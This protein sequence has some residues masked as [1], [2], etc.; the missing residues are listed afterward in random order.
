MRTK[1]S[2]YD[3]L[4]KKSD[5]EIWPGHSFLYDFYYTD[6]D[7]HQR[8]L[9]WDI[10]ARNVFR[11]SHNLRQLFMDRSNF[12]VGC[13]DRELAIIRNHWGNTLY[14]EVW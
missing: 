7:F 3:E 11:N 9:Q 4:L 6:N 10:S 12:L 2:M 14:R 8:V 5:N 13:N 1:I